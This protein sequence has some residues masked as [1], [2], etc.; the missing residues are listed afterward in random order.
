MPYQLQVPVLPD[1]CDEL[2]HASNMSYLRWTLAAALAHSGAVGLTAA[3]YRALGQ[4]FVVRR[5]LL[6]YLRQALP[7]E[8]LVVETRVVRLGG[9]SSQRQT[10]IYRKEGREDVLIFRALTDWAFIDL[11]SGRPTRIPA[12]IRARFAVDPLVEPG[13]VSSG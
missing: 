7:G 1:D 9:A 3:D 13:A 11:R 2:G 8:A 5:H 4:S 12:D 10:L 6:D